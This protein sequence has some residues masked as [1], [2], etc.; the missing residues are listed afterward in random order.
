MTSVENVLRIG[1]A[2]A[3]ESCTIMNNRAFTFAGAVPPPENADCWWFMDH[4]GTS[5][6]AS[7]VSLLETGCVK[8][9]TAWWPPL[10]WV[11]RVSAQFVDVQFDLYWADNALQTACG[12]HAPRL[13]RGR[14]AV[15]TVFGNAL[16]SAQ[17]SHESESLASAPCVNP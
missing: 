2:S 9:R 12:H 14:P 7:N 13:P 1:G 15:P 6:D 4:W 17:A 11:E 5:S 8:F 10:E 3:A 16:S